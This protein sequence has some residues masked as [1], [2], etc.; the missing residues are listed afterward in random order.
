MV[1]AQ[2]LESA[3]FDGMPRSALATGLV[4]YELAPAEMATQLMSYVAHAFG[5]GC[6]HLI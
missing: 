2:S 1:M 6:S 3:E 4:D 5:N